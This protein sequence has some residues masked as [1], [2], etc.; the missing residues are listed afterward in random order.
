MAPAGALAEVLN[1]HEDPEGWKAEC[2]LVAAAERRRDFAREELRHEA[3]G[4]LRRLRTLISE[5]GPTAPH[6][7]RVSKANRAWLTSRARGAAVKALLTQ[8]RGVAADSKSNPYIADTSNNRVRRG[9]LFGIIAMVAGTGESDGAGMA[10]R[11]PTPTTSTRAVW[12]SGRTTACAL[13]TPR[14]AESGA[15]TPPTCGCLGLRCHRLERRR[16]DLQLRHFGMS[17]GPEAQQHESW[18]RLRTQQGSPTRRLA[19]G[20]SILR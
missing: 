12:L 13:R 5:M 10:D 20:V 11:L 16:V 8:P 9:D 14:T 17:A 6:R 19:D 15:S 3:R 7:C 18:P 2:D 4:P 1:Q